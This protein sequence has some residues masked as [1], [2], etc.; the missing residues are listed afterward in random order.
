MIWPSQVPETAPWYGR[1]IREK[2]QRPRREFSTEGS[3]ANTISPL[4][5]STTKLSSPVV[6]G[7]FQ[8][9][10]NVSIESLQPLYSN[11][12]LA[13]CLAGNVPFG[14]TSRNSL[15]SCPNDLAKKS[16]RSFPTFFGFCR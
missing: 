16:L 14:S 11:G 1:R 9:E 2:C 13:A 3:P 7:R 8:P 4:G 12:S 10:V 6:T 15:V 5:L